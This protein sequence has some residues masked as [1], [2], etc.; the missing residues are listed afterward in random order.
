MTRTD[1]HAGRAGRPRSRVSL[2]SLADS[3]WLAAAAD[4]GPRAAAHGKHDIHRRLHRLQERAYFI[5]QCSLAASLSWF[6]AGGLL[7]HE[8]PFFAPVAA[9]VTLG[10]SYGQ[11]L[12]RVFQI[13]VGV[14]VG[15]LIGDA[16]V[17]AFGPG[18]WQLA[19]IIA[20][21]MASTT[22]LG[23]GVLMTT[24]AGVQAAFVA[25]LVAPSGQAFSRWTD[26]VIGGAV[27]LVFA[28][29]TP[30]SPLRKPRRQASVVVD[31]IANVLDDAVTALRTRDLDLAED[32][33][34]RAR[35][36]EA[37]LTKLQDLADDGL[38]VVRTSPFRRGQRPGVQAI[39][40]LL[41][42]LDRAVRNIRVLVRRAG[43]ALREGEDV[44]KAYIDLVSDLAGVTHDMADDLRHRRLPTGM[45][46]D[47]RDLA[48]FTTHVSS[49]P[50]LSS[51]VIRAQVRSAIVDL[52]M[53]TGLDHDEALDYIPSSYDLETD[54]ADEHTEDAPT[55]ALTR[56]DI[57]DEPGAPTA[58]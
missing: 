13:I 53:V 48:E 51:E 22:L 42:P 11:R 34:D 33:L 10:Q 2:Q 17:H 31:E 37:A 1:D 35:R 52:L 58:R 50:S 25:I 8:Q 3:A 36:S 15:V 9:L 16:L 28:T 19:V 43:V 29:V 21:A 46:A 47:L 40:D 30:A 55:V 39:A 7:Q 49:R 57:P 32:T 45:R 18:Y 41:V 38:A 23:T 20:L 27:A 6:I 4:L 12:E 5:V 44:P 26:A 56:V 24:Q 14:A 54:A